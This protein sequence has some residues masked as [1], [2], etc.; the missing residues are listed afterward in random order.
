VPPRGGGGE[1]KA[2][3]EWGHKRREGELEIKETQRE[4]ERDNRQ[5]QKSRGIERKNKTE[6]AICSSWDLLKGACVVLCC[7]ALY[8]KHT[9]LIGQ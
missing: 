7:V 3:L 5:T 8:R 1:Q 9:Q 2:V 6:R 4:T